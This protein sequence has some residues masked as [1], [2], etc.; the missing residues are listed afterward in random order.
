MILDI[1]KYPEFVPW[2]LSSKIHRK[3]DMKDMQDAADI[4]NR[5]L[6]LAGFPKR[7]YHAFLSLKIITTL[8][9]G[10]EGPIK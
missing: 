4:L 5:K 8:Q 2:C 6:T 9:Y 1:E 7:E 3:E 10:I